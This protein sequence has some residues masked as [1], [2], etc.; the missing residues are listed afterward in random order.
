[1]AWGVLVN[2]KVC[3]RGRKVAELLLGAGLGPDSPQPDSK[4]TP[5]Q[6]K[7]PLAQSPQSLGCWVWLLGI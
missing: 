7:P 6:K 5:D 2:P 4:L 3:L 1:M